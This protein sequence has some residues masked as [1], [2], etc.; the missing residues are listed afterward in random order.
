MIPPIILQYLD[1]MRIRIIDTHGN[2]NTI[3]IIAKC[4]KDKVLPLLEY[5]DVQGMVSTIQEEYH[6]IFV[7][8]C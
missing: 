6:Y 4:S 8:P 7:T 2:S 3:C 1:S 5:H